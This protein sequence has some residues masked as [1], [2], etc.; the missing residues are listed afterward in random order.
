MFSASSRARARVAV[1]TTVAAVVLASVPLA[2][3]LAGPAAA[4]TAPGAPVP[5]TEYLA[6]SAQ[7]N[8]IV[9]APNYYF[10]T[11]ASEATGRQAVQLIGQG[12]FVAFTLTQPANA[13]DF[14]YAIPDSLDG[15]GLT[16]PLSLYVN[17]A[18]TTKLQL[19]SKNTWLYGSNPPTE[20]NTPLVSDPGT[21]APHDFYDDVRYMFSST[22]PAGTVVKLQVDAGD[23]A[24]WYAI[25][26]ADFELVAAPIAKPAGFIDATAAPNNVDNTGATDTTTSLQNAVN[27][28]SQ[29]GT[30]LYL[31]QGLYKISS[32]IYVNR[33]T[34]TGAGQWYTQLTGKSVEFAG[35]IGGP[36]GSTNVNISN[37]ALFGGV[38]TRDDSDGTVHGF[39]GG[40][41]DS[42]ISDVWIQNQKVGLWIVGPV[43]NL[44]INRVRILNTTADG[45]NFHGSVTNSSVTNSF[46]RNTQDDGLAI[47][48]DPG[49][50]S[51]ITFDHNTVNSPGI[52]NNVAL[53]GG[54]DI[55]VTNNLLQ[56]TVTRGGGIHLGQRFGATQMSGTTTISGNRLVRTGQFDP[57]WD[58]HVGAIWFWPLDKPL[59][60]STINITNN[61]II[62]SPGPAFQFENMAPPVG[63]GVRTRGVNGNAT[64]NVNITNNTVTNVGTFVFQN[65][66]PG[67]ATVSGLVATGVGVSGTMDCGSGFVVTQGTGNSGWSTSS[68][69]MPAALPLSVFPS[70]TTFQNATVGSATPIQKI[71]V[72][73]AGASPATLGAISGSS[74][75]TVTNDP[76]K[77][78]GTSLAGST[79]TDNNIWCQVDVSFTAPAAGITVGTL[80]V[81]SNQPGSPTVV[82]L[83][84]STGSSNNT[85]TPM[86]ITPG[87]LSFGSVLVGQ[88]ATATATIANPGTSTATISSIT[89]S[90]PYTQTN[91]C[92]ATLAAGASC[93]VTV[94]FRP[95]AGGSQTGSLQVTNSTS[96]F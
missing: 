96:Q 80:T 59:N 3:V 92:P 58:Y 29:A 1:S 28:A 30:G 84:G 47:W 81:P 20:T 27:A 56:D 75:F 90:G 6:A 60:A 51:K 76:A 62:D 33:V 39:N 10:G 85:I 54:T 55:S 16:D 67:A 44:S 86:S 13:V 71:T 82:R 21:S 32:P 46:I 35:Q 73:N 45:I 8:G 93:A 9:L 36:S 66:S 57:G 40:F 23:L 52:A 14:H 83:V 5:F 25:N 43:N 11:L 34:I 17:G 15:T 72:F 18:F 42:T 63:D 2:S 94:T 74:A 95:T 69:G 4:V 88:S 41:T 37:L 91:A 79:P 7:T 87:S 24:P 61:D 78:C 49:A 68:C 77:P 89:A 12:K 65:Q 64:S 70:T 31:P 22:L 53:Y 19:T 26:T 48:S 50:D 38:N